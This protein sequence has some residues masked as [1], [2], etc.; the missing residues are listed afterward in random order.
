MILS[1]APFR[2]SLGGGGTDLPSYYSQ[3]GGFVLSAA[4]NKYLYIYVNRPAADDLIRVKYSKYEQVMTPDEIQH[5]LVRP[6][7]KLLHLSGG[8][9]IASMSDVPAGTGLGSSG[10]YLVGLLAALYEFKREKIPTQALAEQACHIEMDLA[11]HPVGKHDHYLAAFGGITC[12]D[13]ETN[14]LVKVSPLNIS[15]TTVDE[16]RSSVL[17]FYTGILR[18]STDILQAQKDDTHKGS[19]ATVESLHRTKELG[20]QVKEALEK[21][22]LERFGLL[23]DEH[24]QNKKRRSDKISNPDI[25]RWYELARANGAV[26]GKI[27]G[28]GGGGFFMFYCPPRRKGA[29]RKALAAAGLREMPYDFDYEGA[30]ILVNF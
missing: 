17:L 21:G 10:T 7:L 12:L 27:I 25:D 11:K 24:W 26:G 1:R 13:I 8:L 28:A 5:D 22:D 4:I 30:K 2:I 19:A 15:V 23:L 16:F 18:S 3:Y 29:L 20:Y 6:A 14:G 9:E